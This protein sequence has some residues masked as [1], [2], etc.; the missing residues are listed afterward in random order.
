M[1]YTLPRGIDSILSRTFFTDSWNKDD[2]INLVVQKIVIK[3]RKYNAIKV[4]K[5]NA[6][7]LSK[8][9]NIYTQRE[10]LILLLYL[11]LYFE[12]FIYIDGLAILTYSHPKF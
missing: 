4:R 8:N 9:T 10:V 1:L 6:T 3:V 2:W 12:S 11:I 7:K 5:Y